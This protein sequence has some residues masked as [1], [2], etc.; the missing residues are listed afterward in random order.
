TMVQSR[1][2][3]ALV[4]WEPRIDVLDVRVE[5]PPEARNF[6]LI[7]IDYRIRANNAFYN[8]VYPFFLTEGPG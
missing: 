4:R 5:T 8:L 7:R 6:L 3:D 2:Q 1:V